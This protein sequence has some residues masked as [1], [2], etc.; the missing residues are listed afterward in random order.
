MIRIYINQ[1]NAAKI[2]YKIILG[3]YY[4]SCM[5]FLPISI[6]G[7]RIT[8]PRYMRCKLKIITVLLIWHKS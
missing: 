1:N 2:T 3:K 6:G 8:A 4:P 5:K 7:I